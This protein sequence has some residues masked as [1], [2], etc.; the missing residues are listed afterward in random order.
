[1]HISKKTGIR[2]S[3]LGLN[4]HQCTFVTEKQEYVTYA[5]LFVMFSDNVAESSWRIK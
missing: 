1:M 4:I 3:V 5:L 2:R